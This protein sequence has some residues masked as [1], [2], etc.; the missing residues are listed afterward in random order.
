[1]NETKKLVLV[2]ME[3]GRSLAIPLNLIREV[4]EN[5]DGIVVKYVSHEGTIEWVYVK[6]SIKKLV[7][8]ANGLLP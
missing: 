1:M 6:E 4:V 3:N 8:Q 2:T 5:F 7:D